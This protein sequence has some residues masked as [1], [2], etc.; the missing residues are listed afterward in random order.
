M[1]PLA[2]ARGWL[3]PLVLLA[4]AAC[5]TVPSA[6]PGG[7]AAPDTGRSREPLR[8]VA[9]ADELAERGEARAAFA[10]YERV[11]RDHPGDPAGAGALYGMARLQADPW[12]VLRSY[13][14]AH[15]ALSRLL[16]E[17]PGSGWET[18]ARLW[19]AVIADLIAREEEATRLKSQIERL[20][21]TDLDLERRSTT[22]P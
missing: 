9:Q 2:A 1:T 12:G 13:T 20:R 4:A 19:R 6:P 3:A 15:R 14:G 11:L 17:Y 8:L 22:R 18:E 10:A 7:R 16:A 5:S 21:R